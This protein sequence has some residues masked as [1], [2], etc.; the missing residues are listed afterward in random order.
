MP[1]VFNK[2]NCGIPFGAI[3]VG[4]P[5][6]WGNPFHIG[7][8]GTRETVLKKYR[9]WLEEKISAEPEFLNPLKGRDLVCWCHPLP[10]HAD[11]LIEL[12]NKEPLA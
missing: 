4:R 8:D 5:T 1:L 9:N 12:A 10:C 7:L 3:Y 11:V 6:K 2:R